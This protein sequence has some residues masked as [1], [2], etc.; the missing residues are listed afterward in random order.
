[1]RREKAL[2]HAFRVTKRLA[3]R[4]LMRVSLKGLRLGTRS[5]WTR[6][7][8]VFAAMNSWADCAKRRMFDH[9]M[10]RLKLA[11]NKR[12]GKLF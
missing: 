3:E 4:R 9:W 2:R 8:L 10:G 1:M 5:R 7:Q 12:E 6:K 11:Q